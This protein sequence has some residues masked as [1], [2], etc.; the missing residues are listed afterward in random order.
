MINNL[1]P[2]YTCN[3]NF[4]LYIF[5]PISFYL[6]LKKNLSVSDFLPT[7]PNYMILKSFLG[8][9]EILEKIPP[10]HTFCSNLASHYHV[11]SF[12]MYFYKSIFVLNGAITYL[13][14]H[15]LFKF[16]HIPQFTQNS[17]IKNKFKKIKTFPYLPTHILKNK[18]ETDLFFF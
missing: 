8:V 1:K 7:L 13:V 15:A 9:L 17:K 18:S 11:F 2:D 12:I 10:K 5:S 6:G 3:L 4:D 14:W 16:S